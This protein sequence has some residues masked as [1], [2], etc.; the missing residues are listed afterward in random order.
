MNPQST[1][2]FYG[3]LRR[4]MSNYGQFENGLLFLFQETIGGYKLYA[5]EEYPYTVRT[6]NSSDLITV[7]I[8]R[9][10]DSAVEKAIHE[11]EIGVGY[12]FEDVL[13]RGEKTG[14]YLFEKAGPEP[15]VESGDWAQFFGS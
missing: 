10:V 11:L 6:G 5:L 1:Y 15:L 2:A 3:S 4:G 9:V 12:Y 8:F 14:I 13:I 7:E